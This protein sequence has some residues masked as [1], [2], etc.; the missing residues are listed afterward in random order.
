MKPTSPSLEPRR[1]QFLQQQ[2]VAWSES[3]QG[4]PVLAIHGLPGTLEHFRWLAA[5]LPDSIR[6]L[7]LDMPGFGYTSADHAQATKESYVDFIVRWMDVMRIERCVLMGHSFGTTWVVQAA[8][9][10]PE[11]FQGVVLVAPVGIRPHRSFRDVRVRHLW[12]TIL[13]V[14]G[15]RIPLMHQL[16]AGFAQAG[17]GNNLANTTLVRTM[18]LIANWSF[19]DYQT[20]LPQL[21]CP[22]FAA[23]CEDDPRVEVDIIHE[24]VKSCPPGPRLSFPTGGHNPQKHFACE[25][26]NEL[27][28]WLPLL[29][30][31]HTSQGLPL[32]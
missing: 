7:R 13:A 20:I 21:S 3:G 2:P 4:V 14:P 15:V 32:E 16:R 30:T 22:V 1:I 31:T 11:R 8:I 26:A 10:Y 19:T 17:H 25:I 29:P 9:R 27:E 5:A 18:E 6:F 12:P 23:W 24:F 28:T